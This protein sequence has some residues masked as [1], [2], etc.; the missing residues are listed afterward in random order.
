MEQIKPILELHIAD[1]H[2]DEQF[3]RYCVGDY[4]VWFSQKNDNGNIYSVSIA[5]QKGV[6]TDFEL[7]AIDRTMDRFYPDEFTITG[8][9]P[10]LSIEQGQQYIVAMQRALDCLEAIKTLFLSGPHYELYCMCRVEEA[11]RNI[12]LGDY[13]LDGVEITPEDI[14][15]VTLRVM[16]GAD[17][18]DAWHDY[19]L[20]IRETLDIGLDE[21]EK[22]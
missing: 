11:F 3:Y 8:H 15:N 7:Y 19:L 2:D 1:A 17:A 5:P 20:S 12:R 18:A 14:A 9:C 21:M 16:A 4:R 22:L 13:D 6:T 10:R